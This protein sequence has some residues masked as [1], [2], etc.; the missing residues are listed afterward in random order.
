MTGVQ[1]ALTGMGFA[2]AAT[3][4]VPFN[5]I[6]AEIKDR[7]LTPRRRPLANAVRTPPCA[8]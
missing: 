5:G 4:N 1:V 6:V 3:D 8:Q 7:T 2:A